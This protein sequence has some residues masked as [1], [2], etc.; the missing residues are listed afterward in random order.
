MHPIFEAAVLEEGN[1]KKYVKNTKSAGGAGEEDAAGSAG[2]YARSAGSHGATIGQEDVG[3]EMAEEEPLRNL[4]GSGDNGCCAA[5]AACRPPTLKMPVAPTAEPKLAC[6]CAA[7][8]EPARF[9]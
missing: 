4:A 5:G 8:P 2:L 9:R 7:A 6:G 1:G 3:E